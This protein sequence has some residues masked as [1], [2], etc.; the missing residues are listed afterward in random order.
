MPRRR[1]PKA[2]KVTLVVLALL[3]GYRVAAG[4]GYSALNLLFTTRV[5]LN[6]VDRERL[7][8]TV[9]DSVTFDACILDG[10]PGSM[11]FFVHD[12]ASQHPR[13]F[14]WTIEGDGR[15]RRGPQRLYGEKPG[16]FTIHVWAL[17]RTDSLAGE[18]L[19]PVSLTLS[20]YDTTLR[21]GEELVVGSRVVAP[22]RQRPQIEGVN[23]YDP[24]DNWTSVHQEPMHWAYPLATRLIARG[25]GV[26]CLGLAGYNKLSWLKVAVVDSDGLTRRDGKAVDPKAVSC[27]N[28]A[29]DGGQEQPTQRAPAPTPALADPDIAAGARKAFAY[30][31]CLARRRLRANVASGYR[32]EADLGLCTDSVARIAPDWQLTR[33]EGDG[34]AD[35]TATFTHLLSPAT[36]ERRELSLSS[37][38]GTLDLQESREDPD[39]IYG[40]RA[41]LQGDEAETLQVAWECAKLYRRTNGRAAPSIDHLVDS[42]LR[43]LSAAKLRLPPGDRDWEDCTPQ[44]L[45]FRRR[46]AGERSD[47]RVHESGR[48]VLRY[49]VGPSGVTMAVR[50][51]RWGET[52]IISYRRE[53]LTGMF[54]TFENREPVATDEYFHPQRR[55]WMR[56]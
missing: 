3:L 13:L 37:E 25:L 10:E 39:F 49:S 33:R 8:L 1:L 47:T 32:V 24:G 17:G 31:L 45:R 40:M 5:E 16:Q 53:E 38:R 2:L 36:R 12:C 4:F 46:A 30:Q 18:V 27:R 51:V 22:G 54:R 20:T 11:S 34:G 50:P 43:S 42:L 9:G 48:F 56:P 52:G 6:T 55:N 28:P 15:V 23:F 21:V 44:D 14:R 26:A 35:Y 7:L 41:R 19:P 29:M